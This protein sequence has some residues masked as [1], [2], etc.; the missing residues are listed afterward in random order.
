[1]AFNYL[2]LELLAI[3]DLI[4]EVVRRGAP[5]PDGWLTDA[6]GRPRPP[7]GAYPED[8]VHDAEVYGFP[9]RRPSGEYYS[10]QGYSSYSYD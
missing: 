6:S 9:D 8:D 5:L 3:E 2:D 7:L 1:M 10:D 4:A